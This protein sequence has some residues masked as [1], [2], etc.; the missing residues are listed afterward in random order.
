MK[1]ALG[2]HALGTLIALAALALPG[3]GDAPPAAPTSAPAATAVAPTPV[4]VAPDAEQLLAEA[5]AD[6]VQVFHSNRPGGRLVEFVPPGSLPDDWTEKVAFESFTGDPLPDPADLLASIARDQRL[7]CERFAEHETWT[8][9][10]NGYPTAVRLL[11]CHRNPVTKMGQVTLVKTI[12]GTA[13]FY[14]ITRAARTAPIDPKSEAPLAPE[15]MATWSLY[16]RAIRV[17]NP[18]DPAH[19]CPAPDA[20]A[21]RTVDD[22]AAEAQNG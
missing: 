13:H 6:W 21:D 18:T 2:K 7:T 5:P 9:T 22:S 12:R 1:H 14:V 11:V 17:C 4:A 19:P 10:E 3:C 15:A 20:P 8:G 16:L